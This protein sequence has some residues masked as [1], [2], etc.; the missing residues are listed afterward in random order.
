MVTMSGILSLIKENQN[1]FQP[2]A[3]SSWSTNPREQL[4]TRFCLSKADWLKLGW[5]GGRT[6]TAGSTSGGVEI[7]EERLRSGFLE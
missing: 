6:E 7:R 2:C 3:F 5:G 1:K 4:D